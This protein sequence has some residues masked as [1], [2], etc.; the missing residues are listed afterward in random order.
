MPSAA[1]IPATT[2]VPEVESAPPPRV[3]TI[4]LQG[5]STP[6]PALLLGLWRARDLLVILARKEFHVRYRRASF[7]VLWALAL[8]LLQSIVL[9]VV[10]SR[11]VHIR[12]TA[13]YPVFVLSAMVAWTFFSAALGAGA[14]AIVDG[15][16]LS[17]RVYFTR[18]VLPISQVLANVYALLITLVI[19]VVACPL[20]GAGLGLR[21]L[22]MIP[23]TAL[24]VLLTMGFSLVGSAL[25]VYFRD[26]RY[27]V[28]ASLMVWFYVSPVIYPP[29]DAPGKLR[30]VIDANP[31][32][33]IIDLFHYAAI[34]AAG[35]LLLPLVVSA[36]WTVGLIALG[37]KLQSRFDRVFADLL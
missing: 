14:T 25:H 7:G 23:A 33:G 20:L 8:P 5:E 11:V 19:V 22:L 18:A 35:S 26:V 29:A 4:D 12:F 32:T 21:T 16:E 2:A 15:T 28:S 1:A 6:L 34:G 17:S 27:L 3:A 37:L 24:L 36:G 30:L 13:H 9:A 10:F 31:L